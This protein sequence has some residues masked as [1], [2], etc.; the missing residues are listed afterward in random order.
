MACV[1]VLGGGGR[2]HAIARALSS[3]CQ[4]ASLLVV[5]GNP[6][7]AQLPKTANITD[8]AVAEPG[9]D[10]SWSQLIQ[11]CLSRH[12]Q[13]VVVGPEQPLAE[14]VADRLQTAGVSCFGPSAQAARI[15]TDKAFAKQLMSRLSIPTPEYRVCTSL[16]EMEAVI[17]QVSGDG[18]GCVVKACGLAGGKGVVVADSTQQALGAATKLLQSHSSVVL[19][20][21]VYGEEVSLICF[22]DGQTISVMPP[23]QDHKHLLENNRGPNTGG[24]G[25]VAPSGG[26]LSSDQLQQAAIDCLQPIIDEMHRCGTPY[27]GFL[28]AGLMVT[29]AMTSPHDVTSYQCQVLEYNCRLGDPEAQVLLPLLSTDLYSVL[30]AC[31]NSVLDQCVV[32]WRSGISAVAVVVSSEGYP[33]GRVTTGQK[34]SGVA[35][36]ANLLDPRSHL[37]HAGTRVSDTPELSDGT[38]SE[39][40]PPPSLLLET[41]GGRVLSVVALDKSVESAQ[42]LATECALREVVFTGKHVRRDIGARAVARSTLQH[43]TGGSTYRQAGV[44]IEAGERFVD[45]IAGMIATATQRLDVA[46]AV[47]ALGGFGAV[48]DLSATGVGAPG[49]PLGRQMLVSGA[50]GVGTK[51]LLG[52][53]WAQ[54]RGLGQDLV[55][56]CV[57]D[58]VCHGARP[59]FFLDYIATGGFPEASSTDSASGKSS[60]NLLEELVAG[61][62]D[63]CTEAGCALVGGETAEMPGVYAPGVFDMAGVAVGCVSASKHGVMP[64]SQLMRSGDVLLALHASGLHSNGFSL[65][66][67]VLNKS[68]APIEGPGALPSELADLLPDKGAA[69]T[70]WGD[71]L[72]APTRIYWR[73]LRALL[74]I[75]CGDKDER[76]ALLASAHITGGGL[77]TNVARILPSA[78]DCGAVSACLDMRHWADKSCCRQSIATIAWLALHG[79]I[80]REQ[81]LSTFNLGVGMVLVVARE[82]KHLVIEQLQL[83]NEPVLEV[84]FLSGECGADKTESFVTVHGIDECMSE[85]MASLYPTVYLSPTTPITRV[86]VLVSGAGSILS[87]ILAY[88]RTHRSNCRFS[89]V[90]V[91][92]NQA[93]AGALTHA[94]EAGVP[95]HVLDHRE[96]ASRQLYDQQLHELLTS[97]RVELVMLA[98]F[99]RLLSPEFVTRWRGRVLNTHPSLLPAFSGLHAHR[100]ALAAGVCVTG[101]TVHVVSAGLDCGAIVAQRAV[102]VVPGDSEQVLEERV[103][104]VERWLVPRVLQSWCKGEVW[105]KCGESEDS[106]GTVVWADGC[107]ALRMSEEVLSDS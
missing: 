82:H 49:S 61:M 66:R 106:V 86:A 33:T 68:S 43:T 39:S 72:L 83:L 105:W 9:C 38:T 40:P 47:G 56:M 31:V 46:P 62:L 91:V 93:K 53:K 90:A 52:Q 5:P 96:Y 84:G 80:N 65:V 98:G 107:S 97:C 15:E 85:L 21:R 57:N 92:S 99:M 42:R 36:H 28:Y 75:P 35:L 25:A 8:S 104:R 14:G 87:A 81:L 69:T 10:G 24:M 77:V 45:R 13:L 12:V 37:V 70:T 7:T 73:Q 3:S 50:D 32:E 6:G 34:I 26:P 101:C 30:L 44:D 63:G 17:D 64:H 51:V 59:L 2:E 103:K 58:I 89:I 54:Y 18:G 41:S 55:A 29:P 95:Y 48:F 20:R 74:A 4:V 76:P 78:G 100:Q 27:V 94:R 102:G 23:A 88:R 16:Q 79:Q 19:E 71:L 60:V 11:L 22:S 1:L 67:S